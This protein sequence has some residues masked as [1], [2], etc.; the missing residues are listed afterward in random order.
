MEF[1][2]KLKFYRFLLDNHFLHVALA[3]DG[4]SEEIG[5][6]LNYNAREFFDNIK[7]NVIVEKNK[8]ISVIAYHPKVGGVQ[9]PMGIYKM[10]L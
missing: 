1:K 8:V 4:E 5:R 7:N 9:N 3:A 6:E 10:T 2:N